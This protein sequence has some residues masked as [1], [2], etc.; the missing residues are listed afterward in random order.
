MLPGTSTA[1]VRACACPRRRCRRERAD[2]A[3]RRAPAVQPPH[4]RHS[5]GSGAPS[6]CGR[7][8]SRSASSSPSARRSQRRP[9]RPGIVYTWIISRVCSRAASRNK[10][11]PDASC[12]RLPTPAVLHQLRHPPGVITRMRA[13]RKSRGSSSR[14]RSARRPCDSIAAHQQQAKAEHHID[15]QDVAGPEDEAVHESK[16]NSASRRRT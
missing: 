2:D 12:W 4:D 15:V 13:R 7:S 16:A 1:M 10:P 11:W 3:E 8:G 5:S 14:A 9:Q 6:R